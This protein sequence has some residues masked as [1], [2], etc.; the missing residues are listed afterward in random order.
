VPPQQ[1][2]ARMTVRLATAEPG[3]PAGGFFND[4]GAVPW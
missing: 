2:G 4:D 1:T 3:G